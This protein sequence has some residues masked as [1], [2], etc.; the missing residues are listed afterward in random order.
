MNNAGATT[1]REFGAIRV[2]TAHWP[3]VLL[4]FPEKRLSDAEFHQAMAWIA[5][6]MR[7][8]QR[9]GQKNYQVTDLT[10]I[11]EIA[12]A[13]QR[14]YAAEWTKDN[15]ALIRLASVGGANVTPSSI[16]RGIITA[17]DWIHRPPTP[18]A[19]FATRAEA[20]LHAMVQ[21]ER[22][23]VPLPPRVLHLRE[24]IRAGS[25]VRERR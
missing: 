15:E 22:A 8:C 13:S 1:L 25:S 24:E 11:R 20:Y 3:I 19:V 10:R 14:K 23:Y 7:D 4:E 5:D 2:D 21:L 12:P 17:I 16:L 6:L 18:T 9:T